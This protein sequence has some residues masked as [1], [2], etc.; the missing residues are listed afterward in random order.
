MKS[1][2]LIKHNFI[3]QEDRV[4]VWL[5]AFPFSALDE[6]GWPGHTPVA[7]PL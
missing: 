1:I 3:N 2:H 5:Q 6:V 4:E 7:L